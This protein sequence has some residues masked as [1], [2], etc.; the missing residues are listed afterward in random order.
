MIAALGRQFY[1]TPSLLYANRENTLSRGNRWSLWLAIGLISLQYGWTVALPQLQKRRQTPLLIA[2]TIDLAL[3]FESKEHLA[4]L[5]LCCV[6][7]WF[8]R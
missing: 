3:L 6:W 8:K 1:C 5:C 4:F 7:G 2:E